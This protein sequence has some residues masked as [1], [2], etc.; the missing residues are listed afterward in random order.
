MYANIY[1]ICEKIKT[2]D[3]ENSFVKWL[4]AQMREKQLSQAGGMLLVIWV[5][6]GNP[7]LWSFAFI[8]SLVYALMVAAFM[9]R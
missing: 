5:T 9:R 1:T 8:V 7:L 3:N 2:V 4:E 6:P